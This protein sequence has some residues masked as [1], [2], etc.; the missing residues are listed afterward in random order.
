MAEIL[1]IL[2]EFGPFQQ[3]PAG[4]RRTTGWGEAEWFLS[5]HALLEGVPPAAVLSATPA[6]VLRAALIEFQADTSMGISYLLV[7][8]TCPKSV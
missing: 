1:R 6:R 5:P 8:S 3:E 4:L 7:D 2:R